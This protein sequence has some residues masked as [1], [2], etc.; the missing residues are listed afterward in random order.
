MLKVNNPHREKCPIK[1]MP[2]SSATTDPELPVLSCANMTASYAG[3]Q[4]FLESIRE[5]SF[6]GLTGLIEIQVTRCTGY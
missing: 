6:T 5:Q 4:Q 2:L 3:G 1:P